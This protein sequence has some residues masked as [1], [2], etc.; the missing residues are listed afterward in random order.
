MIRSRLLLAGLALPLALPPM[1]PVQAA[2]TAT[3]PAATQ[4]GPAIRVVAAQR[5][6]IVET[7]DVTG[8]VTPRQ[9]AAVGVDVQGLIVR[10]LGA[11]RGDVVRKGDILARL[12][13]TALQTQLV[14]LDATRAQSEAAVAQAQAQVREAEIG[15]RQASEALQRASALQEKGVATQSQRDNAV[16]AY[17]SAGARL[18]LAGKAVVAA[19]AQLGVI[20]AQRR[21]VEERLA[22]TEVRAPADGIVLARNAV[23]GG[24]VS[25]GSGPLFRIAIGGELELAGTVAEAALPRIRD[26]MPVEV[27][28]AGADPV[29]ATVRTVDPEVDRASRLGTVRI[30]LPQGAAVRPGN[31]ARGRI[32]LLRREGVA[33]PVSAL[34]YR[35]GEPYV[36]RVVDGVVRSAVVTV[37]ARA[38]ASVEIVQGLAEGDDVVV[39]A[40]TFVADGDRVTPVRQER[41]AVQ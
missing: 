16:N 13:R 20:A 41:A 11:D 37:G 14:Q 22:K 34:L 29:P 23:L 25:A 6:E 3:P 2:E 39:R 17:D 38:G 10:E 24:V 15:V 8:T 40:G 32:E 31:F 33:V 1:L 18:D 4:Q 26:G 9:E 30:A 27:V 21:D 19:Q 28:V 36:Q 12:D 5:Q 7:L 35:D